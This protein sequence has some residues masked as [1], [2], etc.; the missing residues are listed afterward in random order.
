MARKQESC[1]AFH[2]RCR[3]L[4]NGHSESVLFAIGP[5]RIPNATWTT[6]QSENALTIIWTTSIGS[7]ASGK[8]WQLSVRNTILLSGYSSGRSYNNSAGVH[9]GEAKNV[10]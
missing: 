10:A 5:Y 6:T 1:R 8:Y 7:V 9:T 2:I 4:D 3:S